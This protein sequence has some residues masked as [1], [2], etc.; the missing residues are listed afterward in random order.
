MKSFFIKAWKIIFVIYQGLAFLSVMVITIALIVG[1]AE[2]YKSSKG[3]SDS[4]NYN[5]ARILIV[6]DITSKESDRIIKE[7]NNA[8][9]DNKIKFIILEIN[10]TGGSLVPS[11]EIFNRLSNSKIP[12][13]SYIRE[14]GTSGAYMIA[15]A[16]TK[17]FTA[18]FAQV[19]GIGI[20]ASIF[21]NVEKNNKEG[22]KYTEL[23]SGIHKAMNSPNREVTEDEKNIIMGRV[24]IEH[25][26]FVNTVATRRKLNI[27]LVNKYSDGSSILGT[28]A[29]Q[30]GFVDKIGGYD[31]VV[32]YIKSQHKVTVTVKE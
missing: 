15:T 31:E 27:D 25:E 14:N 23:T 8:E 6:E 5:T 30:Q 4:K 1:L 19:L 32:Q 10:S 11:E 12:I 13:Y 2:L 21:N 24:K 17:I 26:A 7:I 28:I 20:N 3:T 29:V 18:R 22:I 9:S 16:S